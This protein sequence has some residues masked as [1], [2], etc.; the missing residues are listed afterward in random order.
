[1]I[2]LS[3]ALRKLIEF[4]ATP[5]PYKK[6]PIVMIG[7]DGDGKQT[8]QTKLMN[9]YL[10]LGMRHARLRPVLLALC[11]CVEAAAVVLDQNMVNEIFHADKMERALARVTEAVKGCE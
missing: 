11:E 2:D 8:E 10:A 1:M 9:E 5:L 3:Q 7:Y 4:D 6:F